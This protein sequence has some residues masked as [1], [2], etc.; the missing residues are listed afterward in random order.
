MR[1]PAKAS[2]EQT[3]T[4]LTALGEICPV[5]SPDTEEMR[6][7]ADIAHRHGLTLYDAAY[8]AVAQSRGATLVTLDKEIRRAGLGKRPSELVAMLDV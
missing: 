6:T 1:G 3:A 7:A 4:V 2:A 8:A 5:I